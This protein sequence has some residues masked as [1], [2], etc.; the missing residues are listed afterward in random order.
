MLRH[1]F[2]CALV[3]CLVL[4]TAQERKSQ[5]RKPDRQT[6]RNE[7]QGNPSPS[8]NSSTPQIDNEAEAERK[9]YQKERDAEQDAL[10]AQ[11]ARQNQTIADATYW[12]AI[13]AG[14]NLFVAIVYAF[15]A[16]FTLLAVRKQAKTMD[17]AFKIPNRAYVGLHSIDFDVNAR[18]IIILVENIGRLPADDIVINLRLEIGMPENLKQCIRPDRKIAAGAQGGERVF[19]VNLPD[20]KY[21]KFKLFQGNYKIPIMIRFEREEN[22]TEAEFA[23]IASGNARLTV[24]GNISFT[25]G[26]NSGQKS[27]FALRYFLRGKVWIPQYIPSPRDAK[28]KATQE[29][30]N[31]PS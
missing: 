3:S 9:P 24:Y 1:V 18:R 13:F 4:L 20:S 7:A 29:R 28:K 17:E 8:L 27:K 6:Q 22:L 11:Q 2:T 31:Q 26:F 30:S 21:G 16:L 14:V 12:M 15:F 10:Q 23:Q 25:D 19:D 5:P